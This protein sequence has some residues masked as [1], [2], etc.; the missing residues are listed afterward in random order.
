MSKKRIAEAYAEVG[1]ELDQ[2]LTAAMKAGERVS[3][4]GHGGNW[5]VTE[6]VVDARIPEARFT[7]VSWAN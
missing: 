6:R 2:K 5:A 7:V 3:I 4:E 1:S